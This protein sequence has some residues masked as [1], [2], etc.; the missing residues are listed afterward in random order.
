MKTKY[1]QHLIL[2]LCCLNSVTSFGADE[3]TEDE[4]ISKIES[5]LE[6]FTMWQAGICSLHPTLVSHHPIAFLKSN[7]FHIFDFQPDRK[8]YV[9]VKSHETPCPIPQGIRASFPLDFYDQKPTC[10]VDESI[11]DEEDGYVTIMHEFMHCQQFLEC[12]QD[13]KSRLN[14]AKM[15]IEQNDM[16]W[17]ITYGFP[18]RNPVFIDLY[19]QYL[20]ALESRQLENTILLR[21]QI[22]DSLSRD[23]YEYMVW[24]EWKEGFARFIEN[25]IRVHCD[26]HVNDYG[27]Q[28]P[29]D[30]IS[31]YHSGSLLIQQLSDNTAE[32]KND[33]E[34]LF[35]HMLDL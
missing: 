3:P 17:E 30:R 13:L 28:Q 19:Q 33:L 15:A 20:I 24:Q 9:F 1:K 21:R 23:A 14:I 35:D 29:F 18:Y 26:L 7:Y 16:S 4:W 27:R 31:F 6:V 25:Q 12:E 32:L 8:R 10:I 5:R 11:F 2:F 22:R 34:L